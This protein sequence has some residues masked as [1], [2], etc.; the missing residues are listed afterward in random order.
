VLRTAHPTCNK[1]NAGPVA[2]RNE[3]HR[4]LPFPV[5]VIFRLLDH[6]DTCAESCCRDERGKRQVR[7]GMAAARICGE[8]TSSALLQGL[9][10]PD[11]PVWCSRY[12]HLRDRTG[13]DVLRQV[14]TL[15]PR[16]MMPLRR[17]SLAG[18]LPCII[19]APFAW[20]NFV[21]PSQDLVNMRWQ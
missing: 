11:M 1:A 18:L 4:Y 14:G 12:C 21:K 8:S 13:A 6:N 19:P 5:R 10:E 20:Q 16:E 15:G 3:S 9:A 2:P 17:S 7:S